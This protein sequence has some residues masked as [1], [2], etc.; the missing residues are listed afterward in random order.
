[1]TS[2][3]SGVAHCCF[4]RCLLR[5]LW[6]RLASVVAGVVSADSGVLFALYGILGLCGV[7][8]VASALASGIFVVVASVVSGVAC[9][10][11]GV[12]YVALAF[13]LAW[14]L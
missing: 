10:A 1:M 3:V 11:S 7:A 12:A 5:D 2:V 4:Q 14:F 8:S 13:L 6:R 9:S